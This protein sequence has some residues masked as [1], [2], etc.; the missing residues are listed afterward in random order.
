MYSNNVLLLPTTNDR[1]RLDTV[2]YASPSNYLWDPTVKGIQVVSNAG[3][4]LGGESI[5]V[6]VRNRF[7][8]A[9]LA[10][11][12]IGMI[13]FHWIKICIELSLGT[14]IFQI[15]MDVGNALC[16]DL[17]G[18]SA[19]VYAVADNVVT[20]TPSTIINASQNGGIIVDATIS[21]GRGTSHGVNYYSYPSLAVSPSASSPTG[22]IPPCARE[23][24]LLSNMATLDRGVD[25]MTVSGGTAVSQLRSTG[26]RLV[27]GPVPAN[28]NAFRLRNFDAGS[29]QTFTPV[30][31]LGF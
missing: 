21:Q 11:N 26:D 8:N 5:C 19:T 17:P 4:S 27:R 28:A 14:S 3:Q 18:D 7:A 1:H 13:P 15:Y 16:V 30:W 31:V 12:S 25:F 2:N 23:L 22:V 10:G 6:T 20:G 9:V 29:S 24:I